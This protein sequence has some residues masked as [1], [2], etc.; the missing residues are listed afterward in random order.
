MKGGKRGRKP[1]PL[2]REEA[3]GALEK[4]VR[5]VRACDPCAD[6]E[7]LARR[8]IAAAMRVRRRVLA[9]RPG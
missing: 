8:L 4:V 9:G 6:A 5:D 2:G 3:L 7:G 1:S